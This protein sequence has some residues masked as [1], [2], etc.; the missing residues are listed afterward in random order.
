MALR[1]GMNLSS[2]GVFDFPGVFFIDLGVF[3]GV[4]L[5]FT[6]EELRTGV[7][8]VALEERRSVDFLCHRGAGPL[9]IGASSLRR[10]FTSLSKLRCDIFSSKS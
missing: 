6:R 2:D 1:L 5:E 4:L 3:D 10:S 7:E 9:L 8:L